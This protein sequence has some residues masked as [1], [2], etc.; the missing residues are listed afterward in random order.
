MFSHTALDPCPTRTL[1]T[2]PR[3]PT[4]EKTHK[5]TQYFFK[6]WEDEEEEEWDEWSD[7]EDN[8]EAILFGYLD[9]GNLQMAAKGACV[10]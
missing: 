9:E 4:P 1:T 7:G 2:T 10:W 3:A 6:S 5:N 8:E